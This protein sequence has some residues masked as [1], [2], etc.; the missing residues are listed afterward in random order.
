MTAGAISRLESISDRVLE[1]AAAVLLGLATF[2]SAW[3]AFEAARWNDEQGEA[4]REATT[5]RFEA[6]RQF[7]LGTQT[8]AY[9]ASIAADYARAVAQE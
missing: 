2:G 3:C 7:Y 5:A 6:G 4:T 9:D 8:I 1:I